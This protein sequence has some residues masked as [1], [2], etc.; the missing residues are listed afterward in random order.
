MLLWLCIH[1]LQYL[2]KSCAQ[3]GTY[4]FPIIMFWSESD[5]LRIPNSKGKCKTKLLRWLSSTSFVSSII[6]CQLFITLIMMSKLSHETNDIFTF[7]FDFVFHLL[8]FTFL[9][10]FSLVCAAFFFCLFHELHF[11]LDKNLC[12]FIGNAT[13]HIAPMHHY[14]DFAVWFHDVSILFGEY[15][16]YNEIAVHNEQMKLQSI[17]S[18]NRAQ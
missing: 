17:E 13:T 4:V 18:N 12:R 16:K 10:C 15:S 6:L 2:H 9:I 14:D 11:A 7:V 5:R 1:K 3:F 8:K